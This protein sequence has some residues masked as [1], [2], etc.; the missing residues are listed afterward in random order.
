MG[1]DLTTSS[2]AVSFQQEMPETRNS[3]L[4]HGLPDCC[5]GIFVKGGE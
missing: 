2:P 4:Q 3:A 5:E 1:E